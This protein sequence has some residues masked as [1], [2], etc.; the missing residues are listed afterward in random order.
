MPNA[1]DGYAGSNTY[2]SHNGPVYRDNVL[3]LY[4]VTNKEN[5]DNWLT[6][7]GGVE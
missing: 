5:Y 1:V 4:L 2:S 3:T 6:Q 7:A